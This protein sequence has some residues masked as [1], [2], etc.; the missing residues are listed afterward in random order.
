MRWTFFENKQNNSKVIT[1]ED[2]QNKDKQINSSPN[3]WVKYRR[4]GAWPHLG[5]R[6][7]CVAGTTRAFLAEKYKNY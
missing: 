5:S 1:V 4:M 7:P 3:Y 6:N 2:K